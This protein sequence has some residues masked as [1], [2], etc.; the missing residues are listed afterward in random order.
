MAWN[1][2]GNNGGPGN[3]GPKDPWG[4]KQGQQQPPD[5]DELLKKLRDRFGG[6]KSGGGGNKGGGGSGLPSKGFV[7]LLAIVAGLL[8]LA[9]GI[10]IVDEQENGVVLQFGK[11]HT[12]TPPGLRWHLPSPIQ[13]VERVNVTRVSQTQESSSMLTQDENIVAITLQVQ[14]RVSDAQRYLFSLRDPDSTLREATKSAIREVVGKSDMDFVITAGREAVATR[15]KELLQDTLDRYESGL[16][17]TEVNLE[18][19]DPPG[20]VQAAFADAIKAREDQQRLINEAEAFANEILPR[21]R[22]EAA[23]QLEQASAY[24]TRVT[25]RAKGEAA[26]FS[27]V[28]T[29]YQRAPEVTRDRLYLDAMNTVLSSTGKV[30]V[31]VDESSPLLYLPLDK[32][33]ERVQ[34]RNSNSRSA[35]SGSAS[36]QGSS[37]PSNADGARQRGRR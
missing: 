7:T 25:E 2:P 16:F 34:P 11:Y 30:L 36:Q 6:G 23:R 19:A 13:S 21:A 37:Y 20:P 12:T 4:R 33:G 3:Q 31:D 29:E 14:Y 1:E 26:R 9:S 5:L 35:T 28:L 8:W 18:Q 24:E 22:G 15:A 17:V 27:A 10:Y 32:L